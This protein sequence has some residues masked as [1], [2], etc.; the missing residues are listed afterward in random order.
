M[1]QQVADI[2]AYQPP[3]LREGN[4]FYPDDIDDNILPG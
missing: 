1:R 3:D 2:G 4:I